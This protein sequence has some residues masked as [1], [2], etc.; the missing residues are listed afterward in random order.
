MI[1]PPKEDLWEMS[2]RAIMLTISTL[3]LVAGTAAAQENVAPAFQQAGR[4]QIIPNANDTFLIDTATGDVWHLT[5]HTDFNKDPLA[6]T[7]MFRLAR[8]SDTG[9]LLTEY[10]LKPKEPGR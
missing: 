5:R 6:W 10:G 1:D 2:M 7:L 9:A 8:P 3:C 4:F